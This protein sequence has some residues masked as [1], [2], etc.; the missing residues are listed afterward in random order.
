MVIEGL[1]GPEADAEME[2]YPPQS[3]ITDSIN[4]NFVNL[5]TINGLPV[6]GATGCR[7]GR[8]EIPR[9]RRQ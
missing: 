5:A 4:Q 6:Y 7:Q 2:A 8:R 1:G 9:R 3:R